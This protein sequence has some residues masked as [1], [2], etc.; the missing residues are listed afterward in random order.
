M[1]S[2]IIERNFILEEAI[3][4]SSEISP[5][6]PLKFRDGGNRLTIIQATIDPLK[7]LEQLHTL[8]SEVW[9]DSQETA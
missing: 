8:S 3:T 5:N 2:S 4:G 1:S 9:D 6:N 7:E